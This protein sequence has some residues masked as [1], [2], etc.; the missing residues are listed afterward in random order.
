MRSLITLHFLKIVDR[1]TMFSQN[2][3][4]LGFIIGPIFLETNLTTVF[5]ICAVPA[6]HPDISFLYLTFAHA[7]YL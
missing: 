5:V 2:T 3:D 6:E 4:L 7:R 1:I